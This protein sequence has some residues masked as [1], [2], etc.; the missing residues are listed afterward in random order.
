MSPDRAP[1]WQEAA[2]A[3]LRDPRKGAEGADVIPGRRPP[4]FDAEGLRALL[5]VALAV[6][7]WGYMVTSPLSMLHPL[8]PLVLVAH[9]LLAALTVRAAF[10]APQLARRLALLLA[11]RRHALVLTDAGLLW[12]RP[13]GPV[14]VPRRE[15]VDVR[16]RGNW[17]ERS[18]GR[19]YAPVFVLMPPGPDGAPRWIALPPIFDR[20]PGVLAERLMRWRGPLE[21]PEG[22]AHAPPARLASKVYDDAAAGRAPEGGVV[23]RHGRGWLRKGPYATLLLGAVLVERAV[24][25]PGA[26]R[27]LVAP[28]TLTLIAA[29]LVAVPLVWAVL[30]RRH[31][32][33]RRGVAMVLTPAEVL[34]RIRSGILRASWPRLAHVRVEARSAW[35][36]LEGTHVARQL[37]LDRGDDPPIRYEEAYLGV[38]AEVAQGLCEAYR[39]GALPAMTP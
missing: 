31:V 7:G 23:L 17:R 14:A 3:A 6:V 4:L 34:I 15:V 30:A 22:F 12:Q 10:A 20:T 19:R 32:A 26:L 11:A 33:P 18:P 2:M 13:D 27:A 16:E 35:S 28:G 38:P 39:R 1:A 29:C 25:V 24:R 36:L 8:A 9:L 5:A 21:A 37:V